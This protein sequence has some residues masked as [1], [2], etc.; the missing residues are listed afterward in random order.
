M[1]VG[2]YTKTDDCIFMEKMRVID[3]ATQAVDQE[4]GFDKDDCDAGMVMTPIYMN[5][6]K[7]GKKDAGPI[8]VDFSGGRMGYTKD[9]FFNPATKR[10]ALKK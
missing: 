10:Y 4:I 3:K 2:V 5:V 6:E 8:S 1:F 9:Y 7:S